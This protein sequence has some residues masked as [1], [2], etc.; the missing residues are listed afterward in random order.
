M[1]VIELGALAEVVRL[2]AVLSVPEPGAVAGLAR[3]ALA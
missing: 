2:P 1:S 3:E